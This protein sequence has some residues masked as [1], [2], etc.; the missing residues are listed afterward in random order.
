MDTVV[1]CV[2]VHCVSP[3]VVWAADV[4]TEGT[5]LPR[6]TG[7]TRSEGFKME[8]KKLSTNYSG[9]E[10]VFCVWSL[11]LKQCVFCVWSLEMKEYVFCVWSLEMRLQNTDPKRIRWNGYKRIG[12]LLIKKRLVMFRWTFCHHQKHGEDFSLQILLFMF[13]TPVDLWTINR[14]AGSLWFLLSGSMFNL[15][16]GNFNMG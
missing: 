7:R 12:N 10:G 11:E 6:K 8:S 15:C 4:R 16:K 9:I 3:I 1:H 5:R 2:V 13:G 14:K